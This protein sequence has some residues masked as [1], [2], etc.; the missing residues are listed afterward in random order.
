MSHPFW[1]VTR[2]D[3]V[4]AGELETGEAVVALDGQ[5]FR[6]TSITPR[7]GPLR[8]RIT[9]VSRETLRPI[10]RNGKSTRANRCT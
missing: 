9:R 3:F 10:F 2:Q 8:D 4:D 7:A 6:L 5:H 1:S